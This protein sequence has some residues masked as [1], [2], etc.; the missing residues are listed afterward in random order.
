MEIGDQIETAPT[1]KAE[2]VS[3]CYL[4]GLRDGKNRHSRSGHCDPHPPHPLLVC[5]KNLKANATGAKRREYQVLS[6][7]YLE[8]IALR[9]Q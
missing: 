7:N 9:D 8:T 1:D 2:A 6:D 5:L 3:A 4:A